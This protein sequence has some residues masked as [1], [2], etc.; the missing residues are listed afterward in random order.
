MNGME[1]LMKSFGFNPDE[2]KAQVQSASENFKAVVTHFNTRMD[3]IESM[4]A[5]MIHDIKNM[6]T[7]ITFLAER[8]PM[9]Y[10]KIDAAKLNGNDHA[11]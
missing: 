3:K 4:Q 7:C 1:M 11:D 10:G 2:L 6:M 5:H 9:N 8:H